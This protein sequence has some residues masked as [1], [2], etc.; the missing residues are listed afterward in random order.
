MLV[1]DDHD[2]DL[3]WV[4]Q[5]EVPLPQL[6]GFEAPRC[7]QLLLGLLQPRLG[8]LAAGGETA[9]L[10][11]V[12][13]RRGVIA[14]DADFRNSLRRLRLDGNREERQEREGREETDHLKLVSWKLGVPHRT[15][16]LVSGIRYSRYFTSYLASSGPAADPTRNRIVTASGSQTFV[17][18]SAICIVARELSTRTVDRPGRKSMSWKRNS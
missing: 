18:G 7:A 14:V 11:D 16:P 17:N 12:R 9:N 3:G 5:R 15:L 10:E 1:D 4:G 8:R 2:E 6:D 13:V